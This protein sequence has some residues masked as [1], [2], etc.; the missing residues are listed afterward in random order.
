M[1]KQSIGKG[2]RGHGKTLS[3]RRRGHPRKL[4]AEFFEEESNE[5]RRDIHACP[6]TRFGKPSKESLR[7]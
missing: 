6:S 4:P 5:K 3:V 2:R 1:R 7:I